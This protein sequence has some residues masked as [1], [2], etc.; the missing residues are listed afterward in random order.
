MFSG[1]NRKKSVCIY[2]Y[3][4]DTW[5]VHSVTRLLLLT[6]SIAGRVSVV[7]GS[8][9]VVTAAESPSES[10]V[11]LMVETCLTAL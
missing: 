10:N 2:L 5:T 3:I 1:Q 11:I 7:E 8:E 6:V 4:Y 9:R